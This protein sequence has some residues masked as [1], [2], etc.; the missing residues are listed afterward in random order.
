MNEPRVQ[1]AGRG[2]TGWARFVVS[3]R[4]NILRLAAAIFIVWVLGADTAA[5]VA[6]MQLAAL[7]GFDFEGEVRALHLEGRYGEAVMI[8]DAGLRDLEGPARDR[9]LAA[10]RSVEADRDSLLR[11]AKDVGIGAL[12]GRGDS[13]EALVGAVAA[14]FFIVGDVRDLVVQ[15]GKQL[16]DGD[17]DEVVL[18]LSIVGVVTTVVPE[19]DWAPSILKAA[20]KAGHLSDEL[21][22]VLARAIKSKDSKTLGTVFADVAKAA[23]HSS[24]GTAMRAMKH[25]NT[26]EELADLARFLERHPDGALALHVGGA[27]CAAIAKAAGNSADALRAERAFVRAARKGPAGIRFLQGPGR[28]LLK[29]HPLIGLAKMVWKGNAEDV[30]TR[31]T[32]RYD[33]SVW[34]MLPAAAAWGLIEAVLLWHAARRAT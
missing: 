2:V 21:A 13:L 12:S 33:Q 25:A 14:D 10:K 34:W 4:W 16:L 22:A 9:L 3:R 28:A 15:G 30:L 24:P 5:R 8:A 26:P 23:E 17:S 19:V 7:P 11:R 1:P 18:L 20:R 6:R 29:P 27:E 31:F 32:D